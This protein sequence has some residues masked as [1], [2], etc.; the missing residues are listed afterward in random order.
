MPSGYRLVGHGIVTRL[1]VRSPWSLSAVP[2]I[3]NLASFPHW[4]TTARTVDSMTAPEMPMKKRA[5]DF[6]DGS[7]PSPQPHRALGRWGFFCGYAASFRLTMCRKDSTDFRASDRLWNETYC[8]PLPS[9][10]A[11]GQTTDRRGKPFLPFSI[12]PSGVARSK[13][14]EA[15]CPGSLRPIGPEYSAEPQLSS[16]MIQLTGF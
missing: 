6:L 14:S 12:L 7:E 11:A 4:H 2:R 1:A 16:I 3:G 13:V 15:F 5:T 8:R 9:T 10:R